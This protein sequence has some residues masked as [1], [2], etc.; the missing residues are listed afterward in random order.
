MGGKNLLESAL[1]LSPS[2]LKFHSQQQLPSDFEAAC[3]LFL[4][5]V[6]GF[7]TNWGLDYNALLILILNLSQANVLQ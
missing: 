4:Y 3:V 2:T 5:T 7:H 6:G 1:N